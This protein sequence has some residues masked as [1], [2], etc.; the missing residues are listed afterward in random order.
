MLNRFN[1][2]LSY[3]ILR[4]K[5]WCQLVFVQFNFAFGKVACQSLLETGSL[6]HYYMPET[7][8]RASNS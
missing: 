2:I 7:I 4:I 5:C 6:I 1:V 3:K 8:C